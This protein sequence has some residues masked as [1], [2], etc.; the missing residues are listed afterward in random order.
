MRV[1]QISKFYQPVM[2]GIEKVAWEIAEGL[3]RQGMRSNV[4]CCNHVST[5]SRELHPSGYQVVRAA[6]WGQ[7]FSTSIAPAMIPAL[8]QLAAEHDVIHLHM[9]DPMAALALWTVRPKAPVVVHWHSDV[10][11]QRRAMKLYAPLQRWVLQRADAVI[12]TSQAYA[13]S[14][15]PLQPWRGK[16]VVIPIGISDRWRA[17]ETAAAAGLRRR[18]G[19]R[20]IVFGLGRMT[21]YKGFDV[22]IRG[23]EFLPRDTVVVIGGQGEM[24]E[25]HRA[26]VAANGLDDRVRLVG[27]I[28]DGDLHAYFQA[29]DLFCMSSTVRAEAYGVVLL[30]AMMMGKAV[31]ATD[32]GGSGVPWV[33]SHGVTG[34]NVPI[35]QPLAL[36]H[37]LSSVL[38][39]E[40]LR[41]RLGRAA[42]ARYLDEFSAEQMTRRVADLYR[43]VRS[44][45]PHDRRKSS[46]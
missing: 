31:V 13:D 36:A 24:L 43:Q 3:A 1:L 12:A 29:C 6:S 34:Y 2:G 5:M 41:E 20:R 26:L 45:P 17:E 15:E 11:R 33:N 22:L 19:D 14:S 46:G 35:S 27:H 38:D 28:E 39:D 8:R 4:L 25:A 40:A 23:A 21:Y 32:I 30:E 42:R 37:V 9:P 10:I 44:S 16:V 18:F 7:L